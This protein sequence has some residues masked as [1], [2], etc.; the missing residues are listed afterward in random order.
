MAL[1]TFSQIV[2][3]MLSFLQSSRPDI[4]TNTGTVVNDV[5][6]S[7]VANQLSAQNGTS[8][9]VYSSI[10]YTQ[11]LQAFVDNSSVLVSTDLDAIGANYNLTRLPGTAAQRSRASPYTANTIC[12]RCCPWGP[13]SRCCVSSGSGSPG[14]RPERYV[15]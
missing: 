14:Y 12:C 15:V 3:S 13:D 8:Q 11:E 7:T 2:S 4:N 5:V 6:V 9:S 1:P 10:N